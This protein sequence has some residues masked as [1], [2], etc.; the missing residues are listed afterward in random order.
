MSGRI[1]S[2]RTAGSKL[3]F[4]DICEESGIDLQLVLNLSSMQEQGMTKEVFTKHVRLM[5]RGDIVCE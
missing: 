5:R 3:V 4:V 1:S 2:V